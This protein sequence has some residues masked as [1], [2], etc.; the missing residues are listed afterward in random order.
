MTYR[1]M[2]INRVAAKRAGFWFGSNVFHSFL[3]RT[4]SLVPLVNG[5]G[6]PLVKF[7]TQVGILE[8]AGENQSVVLLSGT[9]AYKNHRN[10]TSVLFRTLY[11]GILQPFFSLSGVQYHQGI[12]GIRFSSSLTSCILVMKHTGHSSFVLTS[13]SFFTSSF[14]TVEFKLIHNFPL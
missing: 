14:K 1:S 13:S 2:S 9:P 11:L 3:R 12:S 8:S 4:P 7:P 10:K 6:L 5:P